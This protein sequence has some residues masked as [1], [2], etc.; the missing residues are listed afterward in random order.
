VPAG[1]ILV[2]GFYRTPQL[3]GVMRVRQ[4]EPLE[5]LRPGSLT[6]AETIRSNII[7]CTPASQDDAAFAATPVPWPVDP[8]FGFTQPVFPLGPNP[9]KVTRTS[10]P[11]IVSS[12]S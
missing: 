7:A 12:T 3:L 2:I 1:L 10:I 8:A 4:S 9:C 11:L 6:R 5:P